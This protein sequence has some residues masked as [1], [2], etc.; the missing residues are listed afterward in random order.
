MKG[1]Q[2]M[3]T[4]RN[5]GEHPESLADGGS[6][7]VGEFVDLS[8]EQQK[9]RRV[10]EMIEVGTLVKVPPATTKEKGKEGNS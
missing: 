7:G 4:F 1:G 2:E 3:D 10:A 9:D 8:S 6:I 5:V